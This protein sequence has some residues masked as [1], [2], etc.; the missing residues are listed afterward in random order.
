MSLPTREC[1]LK[2]LKHS[3]DFILAF[4]TPYAG[5]WIEIHTKSTTTRTGSVTPYA[6]VW[7]EIPGNATQ[8]A[9]SNVT[10]YAGVWIEIS[11][12]CFYRSVDVVTPYAGVWIEITWTPP[13]LI[14]NTSLPT[15]ECG[16]KYIHTYLT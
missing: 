15:R 9:N 14:S 12:I 1:G 2:F 16:L 8:F 13:L 4:V 6:G 7:I 11:K 5:V 3:I 10:P